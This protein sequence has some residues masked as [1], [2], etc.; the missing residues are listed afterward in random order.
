MILVF[1]YNRREQAVYS[2]EEI[3]RMFGV[4]TVQPG[5]PYGIIE[6]GG[7]VS[8][9][10]QDVYR[11]AHEAI[12]RGEREAGCIVKLTDISE[13]ENV[14]ELKLQTVF[15]NHDRP[16]NLA[17]GIFKD[18][19][20]QY[21]QGQELEQTKQ[22]LMTTREKLRQESREQLDMIY[23]LGRDYYALWRLDLDR[24]LL[25]LRRSENL[26]TMSM[27]DVGQNQPQSYSESL[28]QFAKYRVHPDDRERLLR[29][30]S[31]ERIREHLETEDAYSVRIR[32]A[33]E[34][35]GAYTYVEWRIV[36]L[37]STEGTHTALIAV[38]D[39][40]GDALAEARQ[41]SLL[42]DA[43]SVAEHASRAK[44][45][46]LSNMSHD[47]RTPMNAIIGFTSIA[48]SHIDNKER[49]QDC[50]EKIMSSSNHLLSLIN[51]IL[52]MSRIES[53]KVTIQEKEC[54][55]SERI[56]NLVD[57]IRPQMRAKRPMSLS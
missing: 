23:A 29:E 28:R 9:D 1:T 48:A 20:S 27:D 18:I 33:S 55:L 25:V 17:V 41:Q 10:T 26:R 57:M 39:V 31:L 54:N 46:F 50:L 8:K 22:K 16:T 44:T 11:E 42:K 49:V 13:Q 53:G 43:L 47:I 12:L 40:E 7:I 2:D 36:R 35:G 32:R 6:K 14:Y 45:T 51:D 24:D 34:R 56:H 5:I 21:Y 38:K 19:T 52:D 3:A 37:I 15:D 4:E 30:A